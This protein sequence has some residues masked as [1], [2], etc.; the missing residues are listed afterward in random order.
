MKYLCTLN[1]RWHDNIFKQ[2]N[3]W[4]WLI[5]IVLHETVL[6]YRRNCKRNW[7]CTVNWYF[8]YIKKCPQ[9]TST[10]LKSSLNVLSKQ[11]RDNYDWCIGTSADKSNKNHMDNLIALNPTHFHRSLFTA[12]CF[13]LSLYFF[14]REPR[15]IYIYISL[16]LGSIHHNKIVL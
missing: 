7:N 1:Q 11:I 5:S 12:P 15:Y 6:C 3:K 13:Q 10:W 9:R 14:E 8:I 2:Q 4:I 16:V